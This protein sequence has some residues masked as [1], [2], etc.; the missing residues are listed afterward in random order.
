MRVSGVAE[1]LD[2]FR[3]SS[4]SRQFFERETAVQIGC[5]VL[6]DYYLPF[7]SGRKPRHRFAKGSAG[8]F[9]W[10]SKHKPK[11]PRSLGSCTKDRGFWRC[12]ML[13]MPSRQESSKKSVTPRSPRVARPWRSR[14]AIPMGSAFLETKCWTLS[15]GLRV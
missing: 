14:K 2:G 13:G 10:T 11:R 5:F 4:A 3:A 12:R 7:S 1:L 15:R 8:E 9:E 6:R